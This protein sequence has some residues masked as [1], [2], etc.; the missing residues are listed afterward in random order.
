MTDQGYSALLTRRRFAQL[1]G[2]A[3]GSV[4]LGAASGAAPSGR[5]AGDRSVHARGFP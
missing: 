3:T 2:M 5:H 1:S 4:L